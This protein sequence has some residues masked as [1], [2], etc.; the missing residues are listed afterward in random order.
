MTLQCNVVSHWLGTITKWLLVLEWVYSPF[1]TLQCYSRW[2]DME[3]GRQKV[4]R[5]LF[6]YNGY[7]CSKFPLTDDHIL[8]YK[9]L[10]NG[11]KKQKNICYLNGIQNR[12]IYVFTQDILNW[13]VRISEWNL[14]INFDA[15]F[16]NW[17]LRYVYWNCPQM[18]VI[19]SYYW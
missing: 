13:L 16:S 15:H 6:L 2:T 17:W 18:N 12:P 19:G 14:I 1:W 11:T 7:N 9:I 4:N 8:Q 3:T 10:Q 5:I